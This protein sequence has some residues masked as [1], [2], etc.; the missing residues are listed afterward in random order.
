MSAGTDI[1]ILGVYYSESVM[2]TYSYLITGITNGDMSNLATGFYD[3]AYTTSYVDGIGLIGSDSYTYPYL[4]TKAITL[5]PGA[6]SSSSS[7]SAS[8][9]SPSYIVGLTTLA[10]NTAADYIVTFSNFGL[11]TTD[12][13]YIMVTFVIKFTPFPT[14]LTITALSGFT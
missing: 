5:T 2:P 12:V 6:T 3:S 14:T 8:S 1:W 7:S 4:S 11:D 13:Y 10:S 9:S